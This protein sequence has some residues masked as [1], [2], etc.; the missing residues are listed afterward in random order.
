MVLDRVEPG[1]AF[2]PVA[3]RVVM[4]ADRRGDKRVLPPQ[5]GGDEPHDGVSVRHWGPCGQR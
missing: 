4:H 1:Q 5:P 2:L 3:V